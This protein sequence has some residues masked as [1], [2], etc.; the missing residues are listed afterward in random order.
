MSI[1][2]ED[3]EPALEKELAEEA[4]VSQEVARSSLRLSD[5]FLSAGR[6]DQIRPPT[7]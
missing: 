1:I 5:K 6:M 2:F 4:D 3:L 7:S